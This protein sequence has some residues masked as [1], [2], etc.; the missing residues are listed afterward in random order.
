MFKKIKLKMQKK[1]KVK[2]IIKA[3]FLKS[4]QGFKSASHK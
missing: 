2:R 3:F 4:M 1:Y